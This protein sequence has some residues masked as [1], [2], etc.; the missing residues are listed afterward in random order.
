MLVVAGMVLSQQYENFD[1]AGSLRGEVT[2]SEDN[3]S[4]SEGPV[5]ACDGM[6]ECAACRCNGYS[7]C[8]SYVLG[9]PCATFSCTSADYPQMCE[10][11]GVQWCCGSGDNCGTFDNQCPPPS[12]CQTGENICA[13]NVPS[14]PNWCCGTG[15]PCGTYESQCDG[16]ANPEPYCPSGFDQCGDQDPD[17]LDWCCYPGQ[18]CGTA[19]DPCSGSTVSSAPLG[20]SDPVDYPNMECG[21]C[22]PGSLEE[23]YCQNP[24]S[25]E[26]VCDGGSSSSPS[27]CASDSDCSDPVNECC[28]NGTCRVRPIESTYDYCNSEPSNPPPASSGPTSWR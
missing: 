20:C 9:G 7:W 10:G 13:D 3:Q 22:D 8:D 28:S 19:S 17:T 15:E 6:D 12:F 26:E 2:E 27:T 1:L 16:S 24:T 4:A 23:C 11:D 21:G 5:S 18:A 14:H 25:F